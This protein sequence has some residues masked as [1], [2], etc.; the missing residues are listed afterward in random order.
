MKKHER[1][2]TQQQH[3]RHV[4]KHAAP[5]PLLEQVISN[6]VDRTK[7]QKQRGKHYQTGATQKCDRQIQ[8]FISSDRRV[9]MKDKCRQAKRGK[10][11]N[12]WRSAA[13]LKDHEQSDEEI[14]K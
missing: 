4:E 10:M 5:S 1:R 13:L 6:R 12:E 7:V 2:D 11:Q 3:C 14:N 8:V 9:E